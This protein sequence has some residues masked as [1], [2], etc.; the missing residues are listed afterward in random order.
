MVDNEN[1][2]VKGRVVVAGHG[3]LMGPEELDLLRAALESANRAPSIHNTQPW[4]W[5]LHGSVLD[6]RADRARQLHVA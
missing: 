4:R 2:V 3:S 1:D 6:L 5:V